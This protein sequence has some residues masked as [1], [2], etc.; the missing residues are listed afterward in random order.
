MIIAES[1]SGLVACLLAAH[2]ALFR[3]RAPACMLRWLLMDADT[4]PEMISEAQD[5]I[6]RV[7]PEVM[8]QRLRDSLSADFA[9]IL[10]DCTVRIVCLSPESDR[11]GLDG[12]AGSSPQSPA[13]K[14]CRLPDPTL[15]F[16]AL[17]PVV[18]LFFRRLECSAI[19][20]NVSGRWIGSA[21]TKLTYPAPCSEWSAG[22]ARNPYRKSGAR[23]TPYKTVRNLFAS[24]T[25][26]GCPPPCTRLEASPK[27]HAAANNSGPDR[28]SVV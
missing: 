25:R 8:A 7:R 21:L 4:P 6:A 12:F 1:Y 15:S 28:K 2:P 9:P 16:S 5:V 13:S 27:N 3:S 17:P 14:P 22:H 18:W 10:R 24:G 11:L 26:D 19:R 20:E 23:R